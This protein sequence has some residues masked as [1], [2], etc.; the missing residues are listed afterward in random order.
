[1]RSHRLSPRQGC[2]APRSRGWGRLLLWLA[3]ALLVT[4]HAP[5]RAEPIELES[6]DLV[7]GDDGLMLGFSAQFELPRTVEDALLKGVP[8]YF[9]AEAEVYRD[10][11]YWRDKLVSSATRTWRLAYQPLTRKYRVT[12]GGL[13]QSYDN[14]F[15]ALASL[16]RVVSWRLADAAQIEDDGHHYIEFSYRLDTSQLPRP[17]QIGIGGQ[18]DWTLRVERFKRF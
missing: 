11:W 17:M 16:R 14:L 2:G 7:R 6:F 15:D 1:M 4:L 5:L 12:F 9:V 13:H 10:R 8:V 18:A 3:M